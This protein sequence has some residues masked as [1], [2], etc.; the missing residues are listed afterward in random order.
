MGALASGIGAIIGSIINQ[1]YDVDDIKSN[2]SDFVSSITQNNNSSSSAGSQSST[3][4]TNYINDEH[5]MVEV[6]SVPE[7][8]VAGYWHY[9]AGEYYTNEKNMQQMAIDKAPEVVNLLFVK[10]A[11]KGEFED[12]VIVAHAEQFPIFPNGTNSNG[13]YVQNKIIMDN[14]NRILYRVVQEKVKPLESQPPH[15]EG[16]LA[17][18]RP[19]VVEHKGTEDD[20]IPWVYGMDCL[21]GQYF[22]YNGHVYKVASGGN[23]I[24]CVWTPD[25]GIWQWVLIN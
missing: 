10:M 8:V 19:I 5:K 1:G 14:E 12:D 17:V 24:P 20:P 25:S 22:S 13:E 23:M 21:E 16:M 3:I 6:E 2:V 7:N 18:Y 4:N 9:W 15:G 11:E